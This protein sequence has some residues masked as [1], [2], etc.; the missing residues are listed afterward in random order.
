[1][2]LITLL[3]WFGLFYVHSCLQYFNTDGIS[4]E[5]IWTLITLQVA[6]D[7]NLSGLR[8]DTIFQHQIPAKFIF[9]DLLINL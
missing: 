6:N 7:L 2:I 4:T 1:M 9:Y 3:V 5:D 8:L